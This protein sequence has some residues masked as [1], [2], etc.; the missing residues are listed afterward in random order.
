M[1]IVLVLTTGQ[2]IYTYENIAKNNSYLRIFFVELGA[3]LVIIFTIK[4]FSIFPRHKYKSLKEWLI[5][6]LRIPSNFIL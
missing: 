5:L 6:C 3:E 4:Y 1:L 2:R